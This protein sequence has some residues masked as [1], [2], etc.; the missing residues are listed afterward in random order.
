MSAPAWGAATVIR[1]CRRCGGAAK[2]RRDFEGDVFC[3]PQCRAWEM[4]ERFRAYYAVQR[5][6]NQA[7][8][9]RLNGV[10]LHT[11]YPGMVD[12]L[13]E[14]QSWRASYAQWAAARIERTFAA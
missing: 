8:R 3:G 1:G 13:A 7:R 11:L 14:V 6:T 4:E 12:V 10:P 2:V 5:S 9:D